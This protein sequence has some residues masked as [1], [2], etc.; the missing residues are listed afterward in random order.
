MKDVLMSN[1][2]NLNKFLKKPTLLHVMHGNVMG[3][4]VSG[5]TVL[6]SEVFVTL[7]TSQ[8]KVYNN[9]SFTLSRIVNITGS[10]HL[11]GIVSCSH[12]NC[13]YA[14]DGT[15]NIYKHNL[16][17]NIT[18]KW[19]ILDM[20]GKYY[21]LS[22]IKCYNIL[23]TLSDDEDD[24]YFKANL[25][26]EYTTDGRLIRQISLDDS[27]HCPIHCVQ[28]STGNF[29]VSYYALLIRFHAA[30]QYRVCIVDTSGDIIQFYGG[31][32]LSG[33]VQHN[34]PCQ[35]TVDIH[36]NILFADTLNNRLQLLSPTLTCL[37]DIEI[38]GHQPIAPDSPY[39]DELNHRLYIGE[40]WSERLFVL[41]IK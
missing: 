16:S 11:S 32:P 20:S 38:P 12:Y 23:A 28:L 6:G 29:V 13:L 5:I 36:D 34:C 22:V 17:D 35:L 14:I 40:C 15:K 41:K 19:S 39:L 9:E 31:S 3:G 7:Y 33:I 1:E 8:I 21:G 2:L 24:T 27:I 26:Q 18:T 4:H 37:G 30:M 25:I 10:N